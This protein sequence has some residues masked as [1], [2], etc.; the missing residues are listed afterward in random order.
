MS[1]ADVHV[2][3]AET[4]E[5]EDKAV[6]K[7]LP[8]LRKLSEGLETESEMEVVLYEQTKHGLDQMQTF[9]HDPADEPIEVLVRELIACAVADVEEQKKKVRYAVKVTGRSDKKTFTLTSTRAGGDEDEDD[10]DDV[11]EPPNAKGQIALALNQSF[12]FGKLALKAASENRKLDRDQIKALQADNA[13]LQRLLAEQ[14]RIVEKAHS[15]TFLRELELKKFEKSENRK[16]EIAKTAMHVGLPA[17]ISHLSGGKVPMASMMRPPQGPPNDS[18]NGSQ[19]APG[20]PSGDA[21][22]AP[23]GQPSGD[24]GAAAL[25]AEYDK[26]TGEQLDGLIRTITQEQ[27]P[28]ILATDALTPDQKEKFIDIVRKRVELDARLRELVSST[29]GGPPS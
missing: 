28:G 4:T 21:Y 8:W 22:R 15:Q 23:S 13:R 12:Q 18:V 25:R 3:D 19:G 14:Y 7:L 24:A 11:D 1:V 6:E 2:A 29:Q 10:L 20:A 9:S 27:F 26:I 16:D 17:L 5:G